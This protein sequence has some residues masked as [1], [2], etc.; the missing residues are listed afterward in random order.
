MGQT[1][2]HGTFPEFALAPNIT[3]V[4]ECD[5]SLGGQVLGSMQAASLGYR[6]QTRKQPIITHSDKNLALRGLP[7][8]R[9][10][11]HV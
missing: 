10:I 5:T 7:R 1:C 8:G 3:Q 4:T 9:A 11:N 6:S 2:M